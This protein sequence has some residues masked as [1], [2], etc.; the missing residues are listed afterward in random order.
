MRDPRIDY[1]SQDTTT[2]PI[3]RSAFTK[4]QLNGD[5]LMDSKYVALPST[6]SPVVHSSS[7]ARPSEAISSSNNVGYSQP[8]TPRA[9][10]TP[11][12]MQSQQSNAGSKIGAMGGA[13]PIMIASQ[14]AENVKNITNSGLNLQNISDQMG[15]VNEWVKTQTAPGL[16][17]KLH[18]EMRASEAAKQQQWISE[19]QQLGSNFGPIGNLIGHYV[20]KATVPNADLDFRTANSAYG[21]VDPQQQEIVSAHTAIMNDNE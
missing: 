5:D 9:V 1:L 11:S 20:G 6:N 19:S 8:T 7:V 15:N 14:V 10:P 3:F 21:K 2:R 17:G 12:T 16:H 4:S 13:A 18:A